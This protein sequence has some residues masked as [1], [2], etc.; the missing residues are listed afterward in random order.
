MCSTAYGLSSDERS[1]VIASNS[2]RETPAAAGEAPVTAQSLIEEVSVE[3]LVEEVSI[4][5]MCGVY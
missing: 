5:G 3:L 4:D 2:T 1:N